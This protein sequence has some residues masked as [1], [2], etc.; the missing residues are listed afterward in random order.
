MVWP[1]YMK[2]KNAVETKFPQRF[3]FLRCFPVSDCGRKQVGRTARHSRSC[4]VCHKSMLM[5]L[6]V[7]FPW[8]A[9]C[10]RKTTYTSGFHRSRV[11]RRLRM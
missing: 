10:R 4:A 9:A 3:Y 2:D 11:G 8:D 1:L 6:Y 7:R 5:P